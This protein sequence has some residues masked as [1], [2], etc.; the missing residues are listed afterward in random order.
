MKRRGWEL[1]IVIE[2]ETTFAACI[3]IPNDRYHIAAF[4]GALQE[5]SY[6]FNWARDDNKTGLAAS[7]VWQRTIDEAYAKYVEGIMCGTCEEFTACLEP[8][9][10]AVTELQS[11]INAIYAQGNYGD[12]NRIGQNLPPSKT[13]ANLAGNSNPTCNLDVLWAQCLQFVEYVVGLVNDALE[14]AESATNDVELLQ[15]VSSLPG[16]DEVGADAIFYY[17]ELLI[18]SINDNFAAQVTQAYIEEVA[19]QIFCAAR[20][21]CALTLDGVNAVLNERINNHFPGFSTQTFTHVVDLLAYFIDQDIDGTIIADAMLSVVVYGGVLSNIFLGDV[22]TKSLEVLLRTAVEDASSDWELLCD[23][24]E[25]VV[26]DQTNREDYEVTISL[27]VGTLP[28]DALAMPSWVTTDIPRNWLILHFGT[29]LLN[30]T[31]GQTIRAVFDKPVTM[32]NPYGA[33]LETSTAS[34]IPWSPNGELGT[35]FTATI[36]SDG[37]VIEMNMNLGQ[38]NDEPK[39][40]YIEIC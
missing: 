17:M 2:P 22:G 34:D 36:P 13:A 25:C 6:W 11:S 26:I 33:D 39:L 7:L 5:L 4:W 31:T 14:L 15:V 32:G 16:L 19:C 38:S 29:S 35:E 10:Q 37:Y 20:D 24:P 3:C 27:G 30:V 23:C 1:P 28:I 8:L 21:N 9:M 18:E 40:L 12:P